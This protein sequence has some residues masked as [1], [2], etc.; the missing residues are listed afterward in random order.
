MFLELCR[1]NE[2]NLFSTKIWVV[3]SYTDTLLSLLFR[4]CYL[5][6]HEVHGGKRPAKIAILVF[7][8]DAPSSQVLLFVYSK[9]VS[10]TKDKFNQS[11][12]NIY[13]SFVGGTVL[14]VDLYPFCN[15]MWIEFYF[16]LSVKLFF[17]QKD[18]HLRLNNQSGKVPHNV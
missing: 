8:Y 1:K 15:L 10:S 2:A 6:R 13:S 17:D 14:V 16:E 3:G 11:L 12:F 5:Q 18:W 7:P 9:C 4:N